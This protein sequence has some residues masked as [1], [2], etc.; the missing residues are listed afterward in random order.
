MLLAYKT[1]AQHFTSTKFEITRQKN[2]SNFEHLGLI[3]GRNG[4]KRL[5]EDIFPSYLFKLDSPYYVLPIKPNLQ[6]ENLFYITRISNTW[7]LIEHNLGQALREK[8]IIAI[9]YVKIYK[10]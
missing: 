2:Y 6:T 5:E 8:A 1:V 3:D 7:S 9:E 10:I 4:K